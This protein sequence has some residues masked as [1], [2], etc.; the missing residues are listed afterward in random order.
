MDSCTGPSVRVFRDVWL[1][2]RFVQS[3]VIA[4]GREP[5]ALALSSLPLLRWAK[6][7]MH[8]F[9]AR[10][11]GHA[12]YKPPP[13]QVAT[14]P[15]A[16]RAPLSRRLAVSPF[17]MIASELAGARGDPGDL[18]TLLKHAV[19]LQCARIGTEEFHDHLDAF[20]AEV[21][22]DRLL[23]AFDY[24]AIRS[25]LLESDEYFVVHRVHG[26]WA[27][28]W[29]ARAASRLSIRFDF[30]RLRA[31]QQVP[32]HGHQR[33]ASG[34]SVVEGT[35]AVRRYQI[36]ESSPDTLT[37]RPTFDGVLERGDSSTESDARDN[38]HWIVAREDAV[39][40][41]VTVSHTPR[42]HIVPTSLNLWIDPRSPVRGDGLILGKWLPEE[43]ARRIPPFA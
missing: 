27:L 11:E 24:D 31:G 26:P 43:A 16:S 9:V 36:V 20:F 23:R 38:V 22:V 32:A 33:A 35:V 2:R 25:S 37:L 21:D 30:A 15:L 10:P 4:T 29:A 13:R 17:A 39:L 14:L 1:D 5:G 7:K 8:A 12:I 34:F 40:F 19:R 41:R 18:G 28:E 6:R 3:L 42:R